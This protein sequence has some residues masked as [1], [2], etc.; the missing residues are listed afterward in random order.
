M[1]ALVSATTVA[2][3][4][5][6]SAAEAPPK[7]AEGSPAS[8]SI[9]LVHGAFADPSAWDK[10]IP[11]LQGKGY[12]VVVVRHPLSSLKEDV[13]ATTR[14]INAQPGDVTLVGHS[15]G[16]VVITEA[17]NNPKVKGLVYIAAFAPDA[18]ESANDQF[19]GLGP[20]PWLETLE[21]YEGGYALLPAESVKTYFAQDMPASAL[22]LIHAKQGPTAARVFDEKVTKPAWKETSSWYV[23]AEQDKI[24]DPRVQAKTAKR[25]GAATV[26]IKASHV[27][28]MS[29]PKQVAA[30]ILEAAAPKA[31]SRR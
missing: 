31:V 28:M 15:Y 16:G 25:I 23:R 24:I 10:V 6:G 30:V 2:F 19:K 7:A 27:V 5:S 13:A 11:I 17:G 9:V 26:S 18:N 20:P 29:K 12:N 14:A 21:M 4:T 1:S 22:K 8:Q 3:L